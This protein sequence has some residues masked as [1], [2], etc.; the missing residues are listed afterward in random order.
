[1]IGT[2]PSGLQIT[3]TARGNGRELA[4]QFHRLGAEIACA[5]KDEVGNSET[6]E[7]INEEGGRAVG[8][9]VDITDRA[10]VTAMHAAVRAQMGPVD[11]LVN[12]AALI[13]STMFVDPDADR[14]IRDVIDTNLLGQ[15]WV[16]GRSVVA[17]GVTRHGDTSPGGVFTIPTPTPPQRY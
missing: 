16:S 9:T 11:I 15:I 5:D 10:Q 6:V 13:E 14:V 12:N 17:N 2:V 4:L 8:F 3:G 7:R 1:M